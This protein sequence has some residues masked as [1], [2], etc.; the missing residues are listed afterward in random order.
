MLRGAS[1]RRGSSVMVA[2]SLRGRGVTSAWEGRGRD[3]A[4]GVTESGVS[5]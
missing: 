4:W 1:A 2:V 5:L 3:D